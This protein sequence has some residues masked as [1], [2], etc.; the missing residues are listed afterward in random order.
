MTLTDTKVRSAKPTD[1]SY[2][3]TDGKGLYLLVTTTGSKLW[4]FDY[5]FAEKRKT[6]S[7]GK[8][9]DTTLAIA[10]KKLEDARQML[11]NYPPIDPITEFQRSKLVDVNAQNNTFEAVTRDWF[12]QHMQNKA[13]NHKNK[14]I[15]R[16]ETYLF[17][18][19]GKR[20][21]TTITT[22]EILHVLR[23]ITDLNYIETAHRC[24][25]AT[26]QVFRYAV[27]NG[28][29]ERDITV[30][31]KGA[32]PASTTKHMPAF[33]DPED[34]GGYLRAIQ[35]FSGTLTVLCALKLAPMFFCR[36]GE[37]RHAKWSE[38]NFKT[39]EWVFDAS[40][41]G[42]TDHIVP[43]SDQAIAILKDLEKVSGHGEWVFKGGR[44]PR[45]PMSEA[46]VNAALRRIGFDTAKDITGHGFRATA[47]TMLHEVH[48][49]D[50][51]AIEH[52]LA[53]TVPDTLGSAYNRT[54]F[55]P[56]RKMMMQIWSDYLDEIKT[57][58]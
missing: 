24:L 26:G 43:L 55:L 10:R 8:Y 52:Q 44:D 29:A 20:D 15:R 34:L 17:P 37:L 12:E 30:D 50:P 58:R 42:Q 54:R 21:I 25:N 19:L 41:K 33:T 35:E 46:A 27:Q 4:R 7:V 13:E 57:K 28:R 49:I 18:W 40:K 2:K 39:K 45:R 23:K 6:L 47:R 53:H 38:I 51:H 11:A 48:Q 22:P 32:I 56:Q 1:K 36:P 14:V 9:P 31:L 5:K 16:F 3:L